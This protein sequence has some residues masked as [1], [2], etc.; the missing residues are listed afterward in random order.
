MEAHSVVRRRG[1]HIFYTV[2]SQMMVRSS[3]LRA[4]HHLP[5][6]RMLVLISIRGWVN[7][8]AKVPLEGLGKL[9]KKKIRGIIPEFS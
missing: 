3:L 4:G 9:P 7:S 8:K 2:G 6:G 5:L 1:S